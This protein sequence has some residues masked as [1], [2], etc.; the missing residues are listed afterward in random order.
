[1]KKVTLLITLISIFCLADE[2]V[3]QTEPND[4][5][6]KVTQTES[7]DSDEKVTQ[8]EPADSDEKVTQTEP[9]DS[10]EKATQT[11]PND[12]EE[13]EERSY[14]TITRKRYSNY[15]G[16]AGGTTT[17]FGLSYRK[18][19]RNSWAFQ[20][21][22]LPYYREKKYDDDDDYYDDRDSGFYDTGNLSLGLT[23]LKKI[24]DGKY[25]RFLFY[26]G[27]NL[28]TDYKKYNYY[29]TDRKW[30]QSLQ[31][32]VDSLIHRSGKE[33][34]NTISIGAGAGC[35]WYV[36]RIAFH[37]MAGLMVDY[38]IE[39]ESLGVGP[40]VEAGVHFRFDRRRGRK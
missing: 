6:E 5:D 30:D 25:V 39:A 12:T 21:N 22:L 23:Y 17:G 31:I 10:D 34:E 16:L 32:Y 2:K 18:W 27:A 14:S 9:A 35:E 1:M 37:C 11:K 4:S 29:Y 28:D 40:T 24:I 20:I 3:T 38:A 36:W 33:V 13:K 7:T 15:L 19:I 8:T 26:S